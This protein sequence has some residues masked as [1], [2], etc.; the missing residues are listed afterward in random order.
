MPQKALTIAQR[1][2]RPDHRPS[3]SARGYDHRWEKLRNRHIQAEPLCRLCTAA[4]K[5]VPA[6]I[7]DHITP[8]VIDASRRLDRTNLRSLCRSHHAQVT[9]NFRDRGVNE[10]RAA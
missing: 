1:N 4:G 3:A 8:I 7:V 6:E 2:P 5:T 10:T 9:A